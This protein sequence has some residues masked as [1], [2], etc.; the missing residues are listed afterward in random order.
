MRRNR[1]P[2]SIRHLLLAAGLVLTFEAS[3]L[4]GASLDRSGVTGPDWKILA[5]SGRVE[6][7]G[8]VPA[9]L[10][11]NEAARG[12]RLTDRSWVRTGPDGRA[13]LVQGDHIVI[14][15]PGTEIRLISSPERGIPTRVQQHS[16]S[17][18]YRIRKGH[19]RKF[20]VITP[21]LV[22]GVKGT[23][24][25][26]EVTDTFADVDV[27]E[28]VVE[29]WSRD[30]EDPVDVREGE[31]IHIDATEGLRPEMVA[32][33]DWAGRDSS[34]GD[35]SDRG[36]HGR[37]R[38]QPHPERDFTGEDKWD[39]FDKD[40]DPTDLNDE[41]KEEDERNFFLDEHT[42][43]LDDELRLL[44]DELRLQETKLSS[45]GSGN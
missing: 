32:V 20:Q 23:V 31:S 30:D 40:A 45:S 37:H 2:L 41:F 7:R 43:D 10:P 6:S 25:R 1:F 24:F 3:S 28:G 5:A 39:S 13:T 26:V 38:D 11:W 29:V 12:Q 8:P 15:D 4:G 14:V 16:G 34:S 36:R 19:R 21:Y 22:A 44:D 9:T 33:D 17:A 27:S 18:T 42:K 35:A